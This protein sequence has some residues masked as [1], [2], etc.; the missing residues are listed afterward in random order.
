M[1]VK[2]SRPSPAMVVALIALFASLSGSA[3]AVSRS[4]QGSGTKLER[5]ATRGNLTL[6]FGKI[7]DRD[8]TPFDGSFFIA[9]GHAICKKGERVISGGVRQMGG[10]AT[11][12]QHIWLVESGPVPSKRGWYVSMN[13]DLGGAARKDFLVVANCER[14]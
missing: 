9:T 6:R 13:S 12:I 1:K 5:A 7:V 2:I 8:T 4:G 10:S 11:N 3:L 14:K